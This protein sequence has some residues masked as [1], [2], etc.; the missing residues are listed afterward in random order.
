MDVELSNDALMAPLMEAY[1]VPEQLTDDY[2]T[3]LGNWLKSYI[4]RVQNSGIADAETNQD[5]E[6]RQPQIRATQ[7]P[8]ATGDRQGGAGRFFDG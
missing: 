2:K 7:L 8:G 4:K 3:R 5:H 1:Y 6:R